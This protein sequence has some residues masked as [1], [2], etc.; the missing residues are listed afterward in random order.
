M[1]VCEFTIYIEANPSTSNRVFNITEQQQQASFWS[2]MV[3][4]TWIIGQLREHRT[5]HKPH[6][7]KL[8]NASWSVVRWASFFLP[9]QEVTNLYRRIVADRK[10]RIVK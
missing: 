1:R 9:T 6:A 7:T 4:V 2:K 10:P 3:A 5:V 8:G